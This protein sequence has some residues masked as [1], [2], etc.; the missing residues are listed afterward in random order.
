MKRFRFLI[1]YYTEL[2]TVGNCE[3][4]SERSTLSWKD[5][6]ETEAELKKKNN[7]DLRIINIVELRYTD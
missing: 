5:I 4:A 3:I 1:V 6:K 7:V 2:G